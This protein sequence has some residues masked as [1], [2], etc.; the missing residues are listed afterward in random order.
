MDIDELLKQ[1]GTGHCSEIFACRTAAIIMPIS[2]LADTDNIYEPKQT[3]VVAGSLRESLL[4]LQ[5]RRA[6]DP[7]SWMRVLS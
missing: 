3:N 1:I 4:A 7:F 5:E 6:P 2:A